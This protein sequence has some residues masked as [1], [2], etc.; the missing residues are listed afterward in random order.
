L[1]REYPSQP[2]VGVGVV[3]V[4]SGKIVLVK[5]G[6]EPAVGK[7]SLPGGAVELG[8]TVR[9]AAI[10]ETKEETGLDVELTKETPI[11]AYDIMAKDNNGHFRF[12]Y[13]LLQ[14]LTVPKTGEL[15]PSSDVADAK[16]VPL[17]EVETYDL[18]ES[19]RDF[20]RKHRNEL[21]TC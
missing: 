14:F 11:D 5:R 1:R 7:W 17:D 18:A 20:F 16:W 19:V 15:K 4:D 6:F 21:E 13:V 8:E 12:H 3:I 10:R 2:V 9:F